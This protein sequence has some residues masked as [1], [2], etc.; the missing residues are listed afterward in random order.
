MADNKSIH[1]TPQLFTPWRLEK[2]GSEL[3]THEV[4]VKFQ[5]Q[6]MAGRDNCCVQGITQV[7]GLK[8][9]NVR[10]A[11]SKVREVRYDT[12]TLI[13]N[14]SCKLF[15]SIGIPCRHIIQVLRTENHT[16]L[17]EYY[18]KKRW[19]KR[20]KRYKKDALQLISFLIGNNMLTV[21][22][23]FLGRVF[24]MRKETY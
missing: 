1:T 6:V 7:E 17:P 9:V 12:T 10:G 3:L 21:S 16:E 23:V 13:A 19:Q 8:I 4:F 2:Q 15:E 24:T 20:C 18:I 5:Q 11:S 22:F 14:C